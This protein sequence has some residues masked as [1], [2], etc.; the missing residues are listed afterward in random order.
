MNIKKIL[1]QLAV[2][3]KQQALNQFSAWATHTHYN[4]VT[5][6]TK[7]ISLILFNAPSV[8]DIWK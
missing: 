4:G 1:K 3:Y 2:H 5:T 7:V 6:V 8:V